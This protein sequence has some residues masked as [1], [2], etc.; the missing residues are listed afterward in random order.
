MKFDIDTPIVLL[1]EKLFRYLL[2]LSKKNKPEPPIVV[3][4]HSQGAI[5]AEHAL[6]RLNP[7]EREKLRIVTLGGGSFI[8]PGAS[9]PDSH[10][11]VS[12]ADVI[13][14]LGSP[15][16]QILALFRYEG[17]KN[18]LTQ[19]KMLEQLAMRDALLHLDSVN[20]E[21]IKAY[22]KTR[23]PYYEQEFLKI[24]NVTVL[25]PD[26]VS[27]AGHEFSGPCYQTAMHNVIAQY[28]K[29]KK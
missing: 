19:K 3:F 25:D 23:V 26:T 20:K 2:N 22:A 10:N 16:L 21:A 5:I 1:A 6:K 9:H 12:A 17:M 18:G 11:Y 4:A 7:L 28:Q 15:R 13:C 29:V 8:L 27:F 14:R 24:S